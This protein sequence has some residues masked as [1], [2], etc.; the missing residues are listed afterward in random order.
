MLNPQRAS[1]ALWQEGYPDHP[2][3]AVAVDKVWFQA[4]AEAAGL[5]LATLR[6]GVWCGRAQGLTFQDVCVF[7][8]RAA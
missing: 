6:Q 2:G 5:T 7:E 1:P 8:R 3:A 4:E